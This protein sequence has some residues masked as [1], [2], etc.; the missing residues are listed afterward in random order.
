MSGFIAEPSQSANVRTKIPRPSN[1]SDLVCRE[2][3]RCGFFF[4]KSQDRLSA[5]LHQHAV[6]LMA[7]NGDAG[8][9][10]LFRLV[11]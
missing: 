2:G 5:V 1:P 7:L 4:A 8:R 6:R 11:V 3:R 10:F 9:V